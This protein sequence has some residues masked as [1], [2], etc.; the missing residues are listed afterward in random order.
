MTPG[1]QIAHYRITAKLGEGGMGAVYRATDTKLN[2]DVAIKVLPPAFAED[3]ARMQRFEREAQVLAS[4]NHPNIAAIYGIEENAIVMELVAG[5][6]LKGPLPVGTVIDYA[7]QIAAGLEAA[8]EKGIVHR[9]LKPAN[10]KVTPDGVVKLL[11][12]GLAKAREES[13]SASSAA[14][15]TMSP[16][17]SLAMTQAGMILGTAAYMA[18]EQARGKPVD[19]RADIWAFGVILYELL[20]GAMLFGGGETVSDSLAAVLTREPDYAALPKDTPPRLRK[21]IERCLRKDPKQRLRDSGDARLLLDEAEPAAAAPMV[22][23]NSRLWMAAAAVL[24]LALA[25]LA[26]IHFRETVPQ[27]PVVRFQVPSPDGAAFPRGEMALSSDGRKLVFI[28]SAAGGGATQSILWIRSFDSLET[29]PLAGTESG[30]F[31]F[32]SPDG[33]FVAFTSG[34]K[35]KKVDVSGGPP[36]TL[37]SVPGNL[38]SGGFWHADGTIYFGGGRQGIMRVAESGG[39]AAPVITPDRAGG[40]AV[41]SYPYLLPDGKHLLTLISFE[42]IDKDGVFLIS[43]DGKERKRLVS[44][45]RSFDFAPPRGDQASGHLLFVRQDTLMDQPLNP[46]TYEPA[47]EPFPVVEHIGFSRYT[48]FFTVSPSGALAYQTRAT[49]G[50]RQLTWFDRTGKAEPMGSAAEYAAVALSRDGTRAAVTQTDAQSA[51]TD[52]WLFDLV[53]GIPTRFTFDEAEEGDPVWSPDGRTV[54][55]SSRRDGVAGLYVKDSTGAAKEE[56]LQK[57]EEI[58]R[59]TDWSADGRYLMF[60]RG[61]RTALKLW[62]LADPLDPAKRK[63]E[64]YLD[65]PYS[66][67]EGQFAPVSAGPP[68][69]VAY[70]SDE[71]RQGHEIFVQ[72]FPAGAGKFQ[73]STGG[74]TQPRWRRDGKEL[75]YMATDGKM[76]AVDVKTSPRFEAGIP[77]AL[78]ESHMS[79][80]VAQT[81]YRYDVAPDGKRFLLNMQKQNN[82][83]AEAITVVLNWQAGV[84]K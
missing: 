31:P 80:P 77:H 56:R 50:F 20:T 15:P 27:A 6:D 8:H 63:A 62:V 30:I 29:R 18:P 40:E 55:F 9:D 13:A 44:A 46:R 7:R 54:A 1:S 78:F 53:R 23:S 74:G 61:A 83:G 79:N 21:L 28:A 2:R 26:T 49:G 65:T 36:Q 16:T 24:M 42:T 70:A 60:S 43:L 73:I 14:T 5:E 81:V 3:A 12:F 64:V 71:S 35:L 37:C 84:K 10:I 41:H 52:L 58:E 17:L 33:R 48:S 47:G 22:R 82:P 68:R 11:D 66:T 76:M 67:S 69:W 57:V 51:N 25:A 38:P 32:W 34:G 75:F 59:P 4:L 39:N 45:S 19:R 72:S